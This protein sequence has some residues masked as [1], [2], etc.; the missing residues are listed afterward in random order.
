MPVAMSTGQS[1]DQ[2]GV[3]TA[4]SCVRGTAGRSASSL[5]G[6]G[7]VETV[8]VG[9]FPLIAIV[10]I[11]QALRFGDDG[12]D[13]GDDAE[14]GVCDGDFCVIL[15]RDG[16]DLEIGQPLD[17]DAAALAFRPVIDRDGLHA[18]DLADAGCHVGE[19]PAGLTREDLGQRIALLLN[20]AIVDVEG[21]LPLGLEH[22]ARGVNGKDGVQPVETD[23]AEVA[24]VD[25]PGNK[26]GAVAPCR[27]AEKDA[28]ASR[29]AIAGLKVGA[30]QF[31]LAGH[32]GDYIPT[33]GI[34]NSNWYGGIFDGC[35][36]M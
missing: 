27:R 24:L 30:V 8:P 6:E 22:V 10:A 16:F 13:S 28:G 31:P 12:R 23:V 29:V 26:Q 25:V 1:R 7:G 21:A 18:K 3:P 20:G 34:W 17:G 5:I 32:A 4:R 2:E 15:A 35:S 33:R 14:R 19:M 9:E 11:V 36:R